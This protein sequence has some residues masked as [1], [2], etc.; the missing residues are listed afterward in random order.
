[1]NLKE[2]KILEATE[3]DFNSIMDIN[4]QAFGEEDEAELVNNL[5]NDKSAE[6]IVSLIA[7]MD[8]KVIGHILFTK[9]TIDKNPLP[10]IYLLAPMAVKPECQNMGIGGML[11]KEGLKKLKEMEVEMVFVLGH[12]EY[13]PKYGF[14]PDAEK[15]GFAPPYPIPAKDADAWMVQALNQKGLS[16]EKGQ[17][18]CAD[19]LMKAEYW[20]E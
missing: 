5:L 15:L 8:S 20:R 14:I 6:P 18:I 16:Q 17:I 10:L 7:L 13:Y 3:K 19:K 9:L 2:I 4:R 1:M 11:I 12:K